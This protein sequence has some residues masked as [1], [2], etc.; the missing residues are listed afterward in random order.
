MQEQ[1]AVLIQDHSEWVLVIDSD[2]DEPERAWKDIDAAIQELQM[3]GWQ[4]V[5]GQAPIRSSF[6]DFQELDRFAP[7]GYRLRRRV[8]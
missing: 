8:Q 6:A 7:V 1:T 3:D 5:Q 4:F 2:D